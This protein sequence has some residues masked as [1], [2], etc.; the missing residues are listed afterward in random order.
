MPRKLAN[1]TAN[2][3]FRFM[4]AVGSG[5]KGRERVNEVDFN[6]SYGEIPAHQPAPA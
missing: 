4:I 6:M 5:R 3:K 1:V 2:D